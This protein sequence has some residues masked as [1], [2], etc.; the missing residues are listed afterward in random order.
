MS[1]QPR[2]ARILV[3][4]DEDDLREILQQTLEAQGYKVETAID[5]VD[6]LASIRRDPPDIAILDLRMPRMDGFAVCAELRRDPVFEHLPVILLSASGTR[7]NRVHGLDLGADDFINKP[8]DTVELLARVRMILKRTRQGLDA[9]PLTRLPGNRSIEA[10]I[11]AA[12]E[13]GGPLAVLYI[14]LNQFKSY[15]DAYGFDA[16]DT[17][18]KA[19]GSLLLEISR[20]RPESADFV[21]HIGGD[22]F[23]LIT[24]PDRMEEAAAEIVRRFDSLVPDFYNETDRARRKIVGVDRKGKTVEFP[25]LSIAV[26]ICHNR[27][28]PLKSYGEVAQIGTELKKHAKRQAGS[29]YVIDRRK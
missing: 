7:D 6:A 17:V 29:S 28:R 2:A 14:D 23:I 12:L 1:S 21:G 3:A 16:G 25:L 15:N 26:G 9:N 4:D 8:V 27:T 24:T 11:E 19:T 22:D 18:I 10:R 13:K 20:A 5:G